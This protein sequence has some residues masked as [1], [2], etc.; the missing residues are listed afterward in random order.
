M[1][2]IGIVIGSTRPGRVGKSVAQWVHKMAVD[3]GDATYEIVDLADFAL[4]HLD[5]PVPAAMGTDYQHEHTRKWARTVESYDGF[6]FVVPEYNHS[7][8]GALKD[9]LDFLYHEWKNKA[10]G[11]VGYGLVGGTRAVEQ[12]RLV[13]AELHVATVR[14]QLTLS[15]FTDFGADGECAP[16][17]HHPEIL[18]RLLDQVVAWSQALA[19]LRAPKP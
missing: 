16:A 8:N 3:R 6:V 7:M 9:A 15:L 17:A 14:D 2:R 11:F 10:A 5:E 18:H 1:T 12:L 4:P 13:M 19:P